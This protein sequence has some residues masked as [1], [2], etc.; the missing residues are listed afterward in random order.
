MAKLF[1][2]KTK[3]TKTSDRFD[4]AILTD[5]IIRTVLGIFF[6][7]SAGIYYRNALVQIHS[8]DMTHINAASLSQGFSIFAGALY[9]MMIACLYVLRHRP[10]NKFV[11][12]WPSIAAVLGGFLM[13]SLVWLKPDLELPISWRIT[14]SCLILAG[15]LLAFYILTHLGRSFSILPESRKLVTAG[16]YKIVRHPLYVAEAVSSIGQMILFFSP[17]AVGLV[18]AQAILQLVRIHYEEKVLTKHFPEYKA[19]TKK[20]AR[21]IPGI[22]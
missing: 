1:F 18:I 8:T 11:G 21:L 5:L 19:Y 17:I 14:G 4:R 7:F 2:K 10:T 3:S 6:A 9:T 13:F 16:P 20:T 15:N 12:W 22:Y